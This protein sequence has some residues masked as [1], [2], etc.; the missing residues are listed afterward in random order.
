[1]A[2]PALEALLA[3]CRVLG[4][5]E[6]MIQQ[7]KQNPQLMKMLKEMAEKTKDKFLPQAGFTT[8]GNGKRS[9]KHLLDVTTKAYER[10]KNEPL[11]KPA[12]RDRYTMLSG[13]EAQ[14]QSLIDQQRKSPYLMRNSFIGIPKES[15][16]KTFDQLKR[17]ELSL[18]LSLSHSTTSSHR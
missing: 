9:Y 13:W 15:S 7:A 3:Q 12:Q 6:D 14:R 1:M 5:S 2:D 4:L 8:E 18:R 10:E 16:S 17:S 11:R